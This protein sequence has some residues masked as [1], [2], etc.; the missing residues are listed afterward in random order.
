[1]TERV[2]HALT[3][4]IRSA[5]YYIDLHTGG[6]RLRVLP[7]VGYMLHPD[8]AVR[9]R[10]QRMAH[11][12]NLPLVWGTDYRLQG[13]SLSV[14]RD[15]GVP[16]IYA[17]Y[18]GAAGCDPAGVDALVNGCLNVLAVLD[19]LNREMPPSRVEHVIEDSR[20]GSGHMQVCHP[21][22][23]GGFFE[24]AVVLGQTVKI[25]DPLGAV[26]DCLGDVVQTV[27]AQQ[28]GIVIVLHLFASVRAGDSLAVI[29]G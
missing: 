16:A 24:P 22:P 10:Q 4:L 1:M 23:M 3:E 5:D 2:A 9:E 14:A 26:S 20:A 29:A 12:F 18:H 7:L 15:A 6:T 17:E 13:R 11:A 28:D 27:E 19:M 25:G 8:P 21:A